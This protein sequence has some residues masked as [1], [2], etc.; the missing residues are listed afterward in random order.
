MDG[1]SERNEAYRIGLVNAVFEPDELIE[2]ATLLATTIALN[3]PDAVRSSKKLI[4]AADR[5]MFDCGLNLEA[6]VFASAF[7]SADQREGMT[8]F[9]EKRKPVFVD[10]EG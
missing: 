10:K 9:V 2:N 3:S 8:A 6:N 4:A 7:E 5:E 1:F